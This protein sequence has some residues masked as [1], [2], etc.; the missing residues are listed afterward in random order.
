[1]IIY[2]RTC[3][4]VIGLIGSTSIGAEKLERLGWDSI[5]H[6]C[7]EEWPVMEPDIVYLYEPDFSED[8]EVYFI[9]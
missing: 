3:F 7:S 5:R 8:E 4:Y 2:F 9:S 6:K 1:L